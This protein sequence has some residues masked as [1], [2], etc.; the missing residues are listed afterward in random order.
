MIDYLCVL[1]IGDGV[2]LDVSYSNTE[3]LK[4]M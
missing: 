2:C 3:D 4:L 1:F